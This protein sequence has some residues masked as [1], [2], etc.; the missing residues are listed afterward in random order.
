M[1]F[2]T[3]IEAMRFVRRHSGGLC[4]YVE[5]VA[6]GE[7]GGLVANAFYRVRHGKIEDPTI[8]IDD[9]A[10]PS[11]S[12]TRRKAVLLHELGHYMGDTPVTRKGSEREAKSQLWAIGVSK[13][14]GMHG[15]RRRLMKDVEDWE[16]MTWNEEGGSCRKYIK[17]A[18]IVR[19]VEAAPS[20]VRAS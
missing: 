16:S 13:R 4:V 3:F 15:I 5:A 19:A 2:S 20:R 18:W 7:M 12:R 10:F 9:V 17:A 11:M 6:P 8:Q 1:T 14:K